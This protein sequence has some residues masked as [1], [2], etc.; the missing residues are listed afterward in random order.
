MSIATIQPGELNELLAGGGEI[1][2]IDV[3][4][5]AEFRAVHVAKARN[6]PLDQLNP[7]TIIHGRQAGALA[8]LQHRWQI[9]GGGHVIGDQT[10]TEGRLL[11]FQRGGAGRPR[12]ASEVGGSGSLKELAAG[13]GGHG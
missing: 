9:P 12:Q 10:E 4:T 7:Q 11:V 5:P 3:R 6:I 13:D 2:L 8:R 1:D